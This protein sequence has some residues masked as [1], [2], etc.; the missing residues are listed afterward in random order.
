MTVLSVT[1]QI[2]FVNKAT[3]HRYRRQIA[4]VYTQTCL[5]CFIELITSVTFFRPKNVALVIKQNVV[6][7]L[8]QAAYSWGYR[9]IIWRLIP[10][11]T[12]K[13]RVLYIFIFTFSHNRN[14]GSSV[15]VVSDYRLDDGI[16][17]PSRG[18]EF[19]LETL[20]P[21]QLWGPPIQ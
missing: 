3:A 15:S 17:I 13:I 5:F 18:K 9:N 14:W 1:F 6:G 7:L 4:S 20:S 10:L 8:N 19:F 2:P 16:S 12:R 21:Y 11:S